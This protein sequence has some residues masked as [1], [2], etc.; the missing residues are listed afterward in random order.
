M[1]V[2]RPKSAISLCPRCGYQTGRVHSHYVR[3][4]AD[5]PWQGRVVEIRLHA[6]RFRCANPQCPRRIF[7]ER[8]PATVRPK[9]T[10]FT[11]SRV[12]VARWAA[13]RRAHACVGGAAQPHLD[14]ESSH[15]SSLCSVLEPESG[16][17][18]CSSQAVP[19]PS[20]CASSGTRRGGR[21]GEAV[22][23][24]SQW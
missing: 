14:L 9:A 12:T 4:L 6:R 24:P 16:S 15:A 8:L 23:V 17:D 21:A 7:T 2:A 20:V 11:G 5:L 10:G 18:R 13:D 19:R 1:L 3:R 22:C